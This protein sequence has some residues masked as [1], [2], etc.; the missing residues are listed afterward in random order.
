MVAM[1]EAALDLGRVRRTILRYCEGLRDRGC[2]VGCYRGARGGRP[3]LYASVDI[4]IMRTVMG[5]NLSA[6]P[7]KDRVRWIAHINSFVDTYRRDGSY[8]DLTRGHSPLH[9]NGMVIGALGALEGRQALPVRLYDTV[10]TPQDV[11][12]WLEGFDWAHQW[13]ES[14]GFWGGSLAYSFSRDCMPA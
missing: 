13:C 14:H 8:G 9:A 7:E 6:L 11:V 5:E 10:R 2:G 12:D 3:D 4:A 1:T